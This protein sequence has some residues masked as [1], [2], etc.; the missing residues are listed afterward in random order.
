MNCLIELHYLPSI[1][2]F[3]A[4]QSF[5]TIILE[6]HENF[7][8]QSYRNRCRII[9]SQGVQ[10]LSVPLTGKSA[11]INHS[12][13]HR[14]TL[15][16]DIKIDYTQKWLNNHWRAIV[17]AYNKSPFFEYYSDSLHDTLYKEHKFLYDLNLE[18]LTICRGWLKLPNAIT[19]TMAYEKVPQT[20]TTDL[21]NL[22]NAKNPAGYE[23]SL[24][25]IKYTQVFGHT[26]A[27]NVSVI[28]LIFCEGPNA[29]QVLSRP[30]TE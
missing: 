10:E 4:T 1:A 28:D 16:T 11:R 30:R 20:G 14:K 17:S 9:T 12:D 18:L 3:T 5:D 25:P 8:K 13:G 7:I 2:W 29:R 24:Q 23:K 15:I 21:R 22:V 6:K 19:E 26:F 27:E